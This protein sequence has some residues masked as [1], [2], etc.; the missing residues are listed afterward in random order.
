MRGAPGFHRPAGQQQNKNQAERQ[1]FLFGERL[2][3]GNIRPSADFQR[4]NHDKS[5]S[6]RRDF[7]PNIFYFLGSCGKNRLREQ[8]KTIA[9]R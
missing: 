5:N 1:L 4:K 8:E 2:H 6:G 3:G 7:S 9:R